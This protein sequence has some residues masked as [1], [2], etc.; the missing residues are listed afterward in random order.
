MLENEY[1]P[2][3]QHGARGL[4][5]NETK[6]ISSICCAADLS[7]ISQ[8]KDISFYEFPETYTEIVQTSQMDAIIKRTAR[9][10]TNSPA[11]LI[12]K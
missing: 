8:P 4:L 10:L 11:A 2:G 9:I 3:H 7:V 5:V 6:S 1:D 12:K